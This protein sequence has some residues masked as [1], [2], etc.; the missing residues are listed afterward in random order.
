MLLTI[1]QLSSRLGVSRATVER[2][3]RSPEASF[4]KAIHIGPSS[5]RFDETEIQQWIE[6]RRQSVAA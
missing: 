2:L 5:I 3:R 6:S 4:P 1:K